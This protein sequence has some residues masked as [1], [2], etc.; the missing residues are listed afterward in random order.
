MNT[1][2]LVVINK[3]CSEVMSGISEVTQVLELLF[4]YLP[5]L[6][7][8]TFIFSPNFHITVTVLLDKLVLEAVEG[9]P[10]LGVPGLHPGLHVD[11][12]DAGALAGQAVQLGPVSQVTP[13]GQGEVQVV[14]VCHLLSAPE[15]E[16]LGIS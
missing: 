7:V 2:V 4:M 14:T 12:D 11:P 9:L 3:L 15:M 13:G 6:K 8:Y 16:V 1:L 5:C 10:G